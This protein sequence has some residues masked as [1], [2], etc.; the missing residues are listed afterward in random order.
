MRVDP[1]F[2]PPAGMP[3]AT[4]NPPP[5]RRDSDSGQLPGSKPGRRPAESERTDY[6]DGAWM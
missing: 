1:D 4:Q 3:Q 2:A 6:D 5:W